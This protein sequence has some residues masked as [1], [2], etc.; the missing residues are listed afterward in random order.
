MKQTLLAGP[1]RAGKSTLLRA[2]GPPPRPSRA[3]QIADAALGIVMAAATLNYALKAGDVPIDPKPGPLP[4]I[5][6][7]AETLH[8]TGYVG[9]LQ[10]VL[11]LLSGLSL[12]ARRRFPLATFW[13]VLAASVLLHVNVRGT[14]TAL[15]TFA[16]TLIAAY[17]AAIY[18]PYRGAAITSLVIGAGMIGL[19]HDAMSL[20]S[21]SSG[22]ASQ[23]IRPIPGSSAYRQ[24]RP[25]RRPRP[26]K[27]WNANAPVSR[28]NSTTWSPT[29]SRSWWCR[30]GRR[31][32]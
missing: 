11:A 15:I 4:P 28:A 24:S 32:K 31:A 27:Q 5:P 9:P 30:P 25:S 19:L 22:S 26:G 21:S 1:W 3:A 16:S 17:S 14:D 13:V 23:P 2:A 10:V 8:G 6:G 20:S 7:F 18:S 12:A 29:M